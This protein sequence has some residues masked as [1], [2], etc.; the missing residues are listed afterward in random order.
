MLLLQSALYAQNNAMW[1]W[2]S[3][4]GESI[5]SSAPSSC[6]LPKKNGHAFARQQGITSKIFQTQSSSGLRITICD[7]KQGIQFILFTCIDIARATVLHT[8]MKSDAQTSTVIE[9]HCKTLILV[10]HDVFD[11]CYFVMFLTFFFMFLYMTNFFC[12]IVHTMSSCETR[13]DTVQNE[14]AVNIG[15]TGLVP[16]LQYKT[17]TVKNR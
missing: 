2:I 15:Q 17:Q 3:C 5:C 9:N 10:P 14:S 16:N 8:V 13:F 4:D 6:L 7:W 1:R 12:L 11:Y